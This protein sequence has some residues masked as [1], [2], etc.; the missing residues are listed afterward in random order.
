MWKKSKKNKQNKTTTT[1]KKPQKNK[2][3]KTF[4]KR[5]VVAIGNKILKNMEYQVKIL[6][7]ASKH[8]L[9]LNVI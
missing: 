8:H 9:G 2:T 7:S 4:K 1:K 5:S 3:F 6:L